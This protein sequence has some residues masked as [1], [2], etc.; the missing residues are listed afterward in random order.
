[1]HIC[2]LKKNTMKSFITVLFILLLVASCTEDSSNNLVIN[3]NVKGL[4]VGKLILQKLQD[5]ALVNLDSVQLDGSS[6]FSLTAQIDEPQ[7]L[8]LYLDVKD[9]TAYD[10]RLT[11]FAQDTVMTI[12]TTLKKFENDAVITGSK[13]QDALK[14]FNKN[15][16]RLNETYTDLMK[17]SMT[18]QQQESPLQSDIDQLDVDYDK[19]LRKRVLYALSYSTF[20]KDKEVAPY[21]LLQE[22]FDANPKLLDSV[23][24]MM[25]KKIQ[26]SLYGKELSELIKDLKKL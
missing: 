16:N 8:Y 21:I 11:F 7:V 19:Y 20:H 5:S 4:K 14:E 26:T 22:G 17:R 18:L 12:N 10:D 6:S 2:N 13:N 24:N 1:M 9:G 23:Y 3:G 15:L 25:P